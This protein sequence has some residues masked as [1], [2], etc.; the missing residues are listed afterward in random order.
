M[1]KERLFIDGHVHLYPNYDLKYAFKMGAENLNRNGKKSLK[2]SNTSQTGINL[3][4][5]T[6]RSD[7]NFFRQFSETPATFED[8]LSITQTDE[9]DALLIK[10]E[11]QQQLYL[12]AGRQIVAAENLEILSLATS[13]F[14][15][16]RK[17]SAMDVIKKVND[18]GGVP[19]LNWA[20]GKW[21]FSRG[22]VVQKA[23]EGFSP[24]ELLIGD[25]SLRNTLWPVPKLMKQAQEAGFKV[26]AG[27]D[28]LPFSGEEKLVGS[29][30]FSIVGEFD[31]Q[32]PVTSIRKMLRDDNLKISFIGKRNDPFT[33][34][35]RQYKIM[36]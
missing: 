10:P 22:K 28:P 1:S 15:E 29:Y 31:K 16:D 6:E 3:L 14:I 25:T 4:F 5:F 19:V 13:L 24:G 27:S 17:Y 18:S 26:I 2:A 36:R 9:P 8:D 33:F 20:P 34:A 32:K 12:F 21:F 35:K 11:P 23:L 30:G 7:C